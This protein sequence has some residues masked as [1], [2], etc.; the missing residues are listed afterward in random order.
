MSLFASSH[1]R[2][3]L[4]WRRRKRQNEI[5]V[6]G[7]QCTRQYLG[8]TDMDVEADVWMLALKPCDGSWQEIADDRLYSGDADMAAH[9]PAQFLDL[10]GDGLQL[11]NRLPRIGEKD[12]AS[13]GRPHTARQPLEQ[14]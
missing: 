11:G 14:R 2:H 8:S 12:F 4:P 3:V 7:D 13:R 1:H 9:Q 5:D 6:I 10:R